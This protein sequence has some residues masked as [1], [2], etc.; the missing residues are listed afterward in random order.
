MSEFRTPLGE[1]V[2]SRSIQQT[3]T[4]A[5]P[6]GHTLSSTAFVATMTARRT[7]F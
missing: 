7:T 5:G 2:L 4:K 6:T 3:N 1:E